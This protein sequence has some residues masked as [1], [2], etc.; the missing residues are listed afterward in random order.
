MLVC[1]FTINS[2]KATANIENLGL[3][4]SPLQRHMYTGLEYTVPFSCSGFYV[5]HVQ[6]GCTVANLKLLVISSAQFVLE[7]TSH[8][9][10]AWRLDRN[11]RESCGPGKR[12]FRMLPGRAP[13]HINSCTFSVF[14]SLPP[15]PVSAKLA[16]K[17]PNSNQ[18][19]KMPT[20][21]GVEVYC[22]TDAGKLQEYTDGNFPDARNARVKN[23]YIKAEDGQKFTIN[24]DP[25]SHTGRAAKFNL[26]KISLLIDGLLI[27]GDN[28]LCPNSVEPKHELWTCRG[29]RED[30]RSGQLSQTLSCFRFATKEHRCNDTSNYH[31]YPDG[32]AE[33]EVRLYR[34]NGHSPHD[35]LSVCPP[36]KA[37]H[38]RVHH[39]QVD[40]Y[41]IKSSIGYEK[42][43]TKQLL[44]T[45]YRGSQI[46][47]ENAPFM[48]FRFL[49]RSERA[50]KSLQ[51]IG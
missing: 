48:T 12:K 18:Q 24:V 47:P 32:L 36:V 2:V 45:Q 27:D 41:D 17:T 3:K 1:V 14:A 42:L 50:I 21:D 22:S 33:I 8:N 43:T 29:Y 51:L 4:Q 31:P 15:A 13:R 40:G 9:R 39:K 26:F 46:D 37:G 35:R 20:I 25:R 28:G 23:C 11:N 7:S 30:E 5:Y 38:S 49:Y 44:T 34:F 6:T 19:R 10:R 16:T